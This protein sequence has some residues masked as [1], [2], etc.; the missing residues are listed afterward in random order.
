MRVCACMRV[1]VC[2]CVCVRVCVCVCVCVR[3]C[4]D[5]HV[6]IC[7]RVWKGSITVYKLES[8]QQIVYSLAYIIQGL[9][10]IN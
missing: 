1:C 7:M 8:K 5:V 3:M 4:V 10:V 9:E 6:S 2:V